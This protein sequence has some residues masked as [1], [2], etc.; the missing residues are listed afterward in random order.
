[1]VASAAGD[2]CDVRLKLP[3]SADKGDRV[4]ISRRIGT[5]FRLI[6]YGFLR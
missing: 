1:M 6:G 5:R 4:A 2:R 3:V